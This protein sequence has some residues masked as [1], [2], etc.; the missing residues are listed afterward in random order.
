MKSEL[1]SNAA[2]VARELEKRAAR[3]VPLTRRAASE[4]TAILLT[5]SREALQS[6][7]YAKPIPRR[8]SGKPKWTRSGRLLRG[9][10]KTIGADGGSVV[11]TI[12]NAT[13]Y[14][15][16]RHQLQGRNAAPWREV[17]VQKHGATARAAFEMAL[18]EIT[19]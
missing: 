7:I 14:A 16:Y 1:A 8:R 13:P 15:I 19:R 3:L 9:E 10:T 4:A 12:D 17:A 5:G 2:G 18:A 11:G 6:L